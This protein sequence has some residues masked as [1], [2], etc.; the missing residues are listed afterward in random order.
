MHVAVVVYVVHRF[1]INL[2]FVAWVETGCLRD[3]SAFVPG[4]V[5]AYFGVGMLRTGVTISGHRAATIHRINFVCGDFA[6]FKYD[7]LTRKC[8]FL[9]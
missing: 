9:P 4:V 5:G 6:S 8:T 3:F 1:D 2:R 7:R